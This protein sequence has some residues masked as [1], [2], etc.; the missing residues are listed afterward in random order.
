MDNEEEM[1]QALIYAADII[2]DDIGK[3]TLKESIEEALRPF[4]RGAG[5]EMAVGAVMSVIK[6]GA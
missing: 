1:T 3:N 4:I 6:E 2:M 5:F